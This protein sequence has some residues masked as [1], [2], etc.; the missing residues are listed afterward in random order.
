MLKEVFCVELW[1]LF[2]Q[3]LHVSEVRSVNNIW[4]Q[5]YEFRGNHPQEEMIK[6][7]LRPFF[8]EYK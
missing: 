7:S 4:M 1:G 5:D 8:P 6:T 3:K 2:F